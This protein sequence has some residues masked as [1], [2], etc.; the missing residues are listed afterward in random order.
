MIACYCRVS[1]HDQK[2]DSQRVEITRWLRNHRISLRQVQWFMDKESG[3]TL[4]R[5]AFEQLKKKLQAEGLFDDARKR[6]IPT[7]PNRIAIITSPTGAAVREL[8]WRP[9][10]VPEGP[11][12]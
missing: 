12:K 5:P 7:L 8:R 3:A 10:T 1:S 2:H 11:L 4:K 6:P 9:V